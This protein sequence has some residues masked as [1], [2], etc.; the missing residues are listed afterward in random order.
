M[1]NF[2]YTSRLSRYGFDI[3]FSINRRYSGFYWEAVAGDRKEVG[4]VDFYIIGKNR[5]IFIETS[6]TPLSV[7]IYPKFTP[8]GNI[9]LIPEIIDSGDWLLRFINITSS[10]STIQIVG[11]QGNSYSGINL[12][13][14]IDLSKTGFI[15]ANIKT[16]IPLQRLFVKKSNYS[17]S[18]ILLSDFSL[19]S[20]SLKKNIISDRSL[21]FLETSHIEK[22]GQAV[23]I[24]PQAKIWSFFSIK[25]YDLSEH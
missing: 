4:Y 17:K 24:L 11:S 18:I 2:D 1:T 6:F 5:N 7:N 8:S 21:I 19:T 3:D 22:T 16:P 13:D 9:V 15:K 25:F 14:N 20:S 10:S 12:T 23:S